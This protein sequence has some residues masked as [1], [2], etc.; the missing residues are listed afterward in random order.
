T[1][2]CR[3]AQA[4]I[5][6]AIGWSRLPAFSDHPDL[7]NY[8]DGIYKGLLRWWLVLSL[9]VAHATAED[10]VYIPKGMTVLVNTWHFVRSFA[11][12]AILHDA[13]AYPE[14]EEFK[15]ESFLTED[16]KVRDDLLVYAAGPCVG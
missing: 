2:T 11:H 16:W 13:E 15:P 9:S 14:P 6:Q 7:P 3:R 5:D 1:R 12:R 8:V 4:E 10:D